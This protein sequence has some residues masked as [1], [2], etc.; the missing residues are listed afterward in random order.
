MKNKILALVL[1]AVTALAAPAMAD[2]LVFTEYGVSYGSIIT[3]R[4][5]EN[6]TT[7]TYDTMLIDAKVGVSA[8][9]WVEAYIGAGFYPFI[10]TANPEENYTFVPLFAGIKVNAFP[11]WTVYPSISFEYG[12]AAA[13]K[14]TQYAVM[15]G[16]N[17]V[18]FDRDNAWWSSYYNFGLA[19]NWKFEDIAVLS[20]KIERPSYTNL[21][22]SY[23]EIQV[24]KAGLAWQ[25]YY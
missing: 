2:R 9:R 5:V 13:N 1:L 15:Y 7:G 21:N 24:M 14:H 17:K 6:N 12:T 10:F 4:N 11:E 8:L 16:P 23:G 3:P 25:I 18:M 22:K 19:I 20:L